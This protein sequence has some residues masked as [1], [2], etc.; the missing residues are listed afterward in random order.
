MGLAALVTF[1]AD[2]PYSP[3]DPIAHLL[4]GD[5]EVLEA[6][7]DV[8]LDEGSDEAILGVLEEDAQVPADLEGFRGRVAAGHPHQAR[9]GQQ[10]AVQEADEGGL[11]AT[12]RTDHADVLA[13]AE[14]EADLVE[15]GVFRARVR[16][17]HSLARDGEGPTIAGPFAWVLHVWGYSVVWLTS[18]R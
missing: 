17:A 15:R 2:G 11:P 3:G 13:S 6:E 8:V 16:V 14:P 5:A 10:K 18:S 7:G 4:A 1:E 9:V 12:V